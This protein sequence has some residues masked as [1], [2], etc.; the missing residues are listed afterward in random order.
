L[1]R[2]VVGDDL[3]AGVV[4]ESVVERGA[5]GA[6]ADVEPVG[7]DKRQHFRQRCEGLQI[8]VEALLTEIAAF[9]GNEGATVGGDADHTGGHLGRSLG[10][11][12]Q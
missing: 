5:V 10:S 11:D 3:D 12:G 7:G 4:G 2:A 1:D 9:L 6:R 8:D